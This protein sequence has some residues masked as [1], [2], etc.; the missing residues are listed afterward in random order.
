MLFSLRHRLVIVALL[1]LDL[2]MVG[3]LAI[4]WHSGQGDI[5][6]TVA[7]ILAGI[8]ATLTKIYQNQTGRQAPPDVIKARL[9]AILVMIPFLILSAVA[10]VVIRAISSISLH[11]AE[12]AAY[13]LA[14]LGAVAALG[15]YYLHRPP[16]PP[17][18]PR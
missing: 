4:E 7:A 17:R 6:V 13:G 1:L 12:A 5:S 3:L 15:V 8:V 2:L 14:L 10:F 9:R 11:V 18:G 16:S